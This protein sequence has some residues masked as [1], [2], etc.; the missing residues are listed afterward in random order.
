M[1]SNNDAE[2]ILE[3]ALYTA[4]TPTSVPKDVPQPSI[5]GTDRHEEL[6][7][8]QTTGNPTDE[9]KSSQEASSDARK[10]EYEAQVQKWRAKSAEARE[11][12]EKERAKW[13]DIRA[14]QKE[15]AARR[16][17]S[18]K[19][20]EGE[21]VT[22]TKA[23]H[24]PDTPVIT[25]SEISER[26]GESEGPTQADLTDTSQNWEDIHSSVTSSFPSMTFPERTAT[27]S[28][29]PPPA[30][31]Q[32]DVSQTATLAAFDPSLSVRTRIKAVL[33]SLAINLLLPFVNGVMLGFGEVFAKNVVIGWFGWQR[34]GSTAGSRGIGRRQ[35]WSRWWSR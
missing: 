33:A 34:P 28:P 19:A 7:Q 13:E 17:T 6:A 9:S 18:P 35:W 20:S 24:S 12:A 3:A 26:H 25:S 32:A 8:P 2:N 16:E 30:R 1:S 15:E 22:A 10:E 4:F 27:P 29:P 14:A 21:K 11:K 31:R 23:E 5:S